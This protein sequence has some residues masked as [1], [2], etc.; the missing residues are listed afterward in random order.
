MKDYSIKIVD[1]HHVVD[2]KPVEETNEGTEIMLEILKLM[3]GYKLV[4]IG[5]DAIKDIKAC[6]LED[7]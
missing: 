3:T 6:E 2:M 4:E 1:G 5:V 7:K